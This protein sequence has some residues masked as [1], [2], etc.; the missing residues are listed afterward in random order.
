MSNLLGVIFGEDFVKTPCVRHTVHP[1]DHEL[2]EF[3]NLKEHNGIIAGGAALSWY[4]N[5]PVGNH[6]VDIFFS[7]MNQYQKFFN[8]LVNSSSH[9]DHSSNDADTFEVVTKNKTTYKVQIIK[10][11]FGNS[12]EQ[13]INDFDISVSKIATDGVKWYMGKT[14]AHDLKNKILRFDKIGP[15][16]L[17]RYIKYQAYGFEP[18]DGLWDKI[19]QTPGLIWN[20]E[21][22][23]GDYD[24]N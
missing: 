21:N 23:V 14:F 12:P 20:F 16:A 15:S 8:H 9:L 24:A 22:H 2:F 1:N 18:E 13:I 11:R 4:Q 17:K 6:D 5:Y 10:T 19:L 3:L 7:S